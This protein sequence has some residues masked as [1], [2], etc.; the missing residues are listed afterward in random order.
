MIQN[1]AKSFTDA[2]L[3]LQETMMSG[4]SEAQFG[5]IVIVL[6]VFVIVMSYKMY[7]KNKKHTDLLPGL[8]FILIAIMSMSLMFAG[9]NKQYNPAEY[10]KYSRSWQNSVKL[11]VKEITQQI[12][13]LQNKRQQKIQE[14]EEQL[15]QQVTEQY[16]KNNK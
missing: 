7:A 14:Y 9:I 1:P 15:K 13:A 8:A 6:C 5:A 16:R 4:K 12:S 11:H 10:A 3:I 2:Q